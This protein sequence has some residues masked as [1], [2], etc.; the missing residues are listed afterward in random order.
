MD[1][2]G[3][4]FWM[5]A[6]KSDWDIIDPV[7]EYDN[8]SR[9]LK[10]SSQRATPFNQERNAIEL[11]LA[12]SH[13]QKIPATLDEEGTLAFWDDAEKAVI[14][15]NSLGAR[16]KIFVPAIDRVPTDICMGFDGVLYIA[17]DGKV[18]MHDQK[19]RWST[20]ILSEMGFSAWRLS[21]IAEG[22]VWVLD[23]EHAKLAKVQGM[24]LVT[25]PGPYADD[26]FRPCEEN[27]NPP[28]LT[29]I[30]SLEFSTLEQPVAIATNDSCESNNSELI[31]LCWNE[32]GSASVRS[33]TKR[34]L[35]IAKA[36][37]GVVYPY[38]IDWLDVNK[39]A[40]L[41]ANVTEASVFSVD[42]RSN[43]LFAV[44]DF[45]PLRNHDATPFI[46]HVNSQPY[47]TSSKEKAGHIITTVKRLNPISLPSFSRTGGAENGKTLD[48]GNA[49]T[50][51]HRLYLEAIIPKQCSLEVELAVVDELLGEEG[52]I[53]HKHHFG[54]SIGFDNSELKNHELPPQG[55]WLTYPSELPHHQGLLDCPTVENQSGLFTVLIQ[56][57]GLQVRSLSGRYLKVRVTLHGNGRQTPELIALRAYGSRF[58]YVDNYFP[59]FYRENL[60]GPDADLPG[61]TTPSD[62]L[63]RSLLNMEGLFTQIQDRIENSEL[64]TQPQSV[65][66]ESLDWLA[67]WIGLTLDP[68]MP[69]ERKRGFIEIAS[70]LYRWHGTL[71]G[72][73]AA[74]EVSS[75]GQIS[76]GNIIVLE[77]YRLRRTVATILGA[78]LAIKDDPLIVGTVESGNSY[79]GDTLFLGNELE[80]EFLALFNIKK[81]LSEIESDAIDLLFERLAYRVTVL[82]HAD[83]QREELGLLKRIVEM[84]TP[85]HVEAR[86]VKAT[87]PFLVGM[88]S[89]VG[90]DTY[91]D[92]ARNRNPVRVN[93]SYIG[94][95]DYIHTSA[96]F[97]SPYG[98]T[99]LYG[100][101]E[102]LKKPIAKISANDGN[103]V[104]Y[105]ES[106]MLNSN[107]SRAF[108]NRS[109]V[110]RI[111][112]YLQ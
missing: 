42:N 69:E 14:I 62:F 37:Q 89:L 51:W 56:R 32:T 38:S 73:K 82:V 9:S 27:P 58:S 105:G 48:S 43:E 72:L 109:L 84:E 104:E 17:I 71:K 34:K 28:R 77:D 1:A 85:A 91:L 22:G 59:E 78:D 74:I 24:P 66:Q 33:V 108:G 112:E 13:L 92:R 20:V 47:Y 23:R 102:A 95:S 98:V 2:N 96:K 50:T 16:K 3:Q 26:I 45:Y 44:G 39:F 106:F 94:L 5:L 54:K 110:R 63:E 107:G 65:P 64:L 31:V 18:L 67:S 25:A 21:A 4:R 81:G 52:I 103:D 36:L 93:E 70:R 76:A 46:H 6:D 86:V 35:S 53:W 19:W 41:L 8:T 99:H 79:V 60:F 97:D 80:K 101:S 75:G 90:V 40:V 57:S 55:V 7:I 61:S 30:N 49:Q 15:D 29:V 11:A 12:E 88:A 111:W 10:L 68:V 100:D 87:R 83:L